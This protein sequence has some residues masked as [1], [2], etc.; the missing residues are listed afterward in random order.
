MNL[1]EGLG[2]QDPAIGEGPAGRLTEL[3]SALSI[4]ENLGPAAP[5]SA[6]YKKMY[7]HTSSMAKIGVWEFDLIANELRWTDAI[8]DLF[9]IPLGKPTDRAAVVQ[10]YHEDSRAKMELLR[11]DAIRTGGSFSLDIEI[12]TAKGKHRWLHLTAD[13]EQENG[14]SVRIFGTKQDITERKAAQ[15][16]VRL[17]QK[18]LIHSSGR[19]AMSTMAATLAHEL[20]QPMAAIANY[21]SGV[22]RLLGPVEAPH[23]AVQGLKEIEANVLRA[24][25][26]IR[27]M[28]L[29][30]ERGRG[31]TEEVDLASILYGAANLSGV[32]SED[33]RF[34]YQCRHSGMVMA[35]SVQ[36]EQ[37][38]INLIKNACEALQDADEK[39]IRVCTRDEA[40]QVVVSISDTGPGIPDH[41]K[42]FEATNS[43]KQH[44]MGIGLSICRTI[45]EANGGRIW[46]E[47]PAQGAS[48]C[49][50]LPK[51][52]G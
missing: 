13:V 7:E 18:E 6:N 43:T 46:A 31:R 14:Q 32:V 15:E 28:R 16:Q 19:H 17:L 52:S 33:I 27:R 1:D 2:R 21:V 24:G 37:V 42:L 41:T 5:F 20:N 23:L 22:S 30:A 12:T 44:G 51:T 50:S 8:Y 4:V 3:A 39:V 36:V 38:A 26:I 29:M 10:L 25:E 48:L 35:D 45:V 9:E 34:E 40:G 11:A 49:F 47:R